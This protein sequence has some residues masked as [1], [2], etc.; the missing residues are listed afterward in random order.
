MLL[1]GLG[2]NHSGFDL[3]GRSLARWLAERGHDVWLP[4]L[5]G[6]GAS[7]ARSYDWHIDEYLRQDLPAI[8]E[9]ILGT[10]GQEQLHWVGHSM[11]GV[12]LMCY[13]ILEPEAPI[14][15]GVCVASALD[16]RVGATGFR[17]LLALRPALERLGLIP[18]GGLIHLL[19]PALGRGSRAVERFNLWPENVEPE[20]T[21][22]LHARVFHAIPASL[23]ASLATTF[24]E[25]GFRL[26][27]GQTFLGRADRFAA[28]T[29]LIAGS[30]DMQVSAEAVRHTASLLGPARALAFGREHGHATDY[31][32][33]DLIIGRQAPEEVWPELAGWLEGGAR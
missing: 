26:R 24:E 19:A 32:H 15:R 5:R 7:L 2:A 6:H 20:L 23:L 18:Y 3:P 17:P 33:F 27:S 9:T 4:E 13:G 21:R 1:H 29:L 14:A 22:R 8:L 10:T 25:T 30:R 12:L 11:G 16:Y 31:G 28:P